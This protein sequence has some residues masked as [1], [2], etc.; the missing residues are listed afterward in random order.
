MENFG[1]I[2]YRETR[3]FYNNRTST[4]SNKQGVALVI[5]HEVCLQKKYFILFL[6][7]L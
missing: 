4:S 2:I 7:F 6:I 3:L 5:A 1:C